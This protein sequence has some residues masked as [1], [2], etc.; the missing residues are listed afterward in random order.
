MSLPAESA[1]ATRSEPDQ[2]RPTRLGRADQP[3]GRNRH[4]E[5]A[6]V[7]EC[8]RTALRDSS[9]GRPGGGPHFP[10]GTLAMEP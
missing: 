4:L 8:N 7:R 1:I 6:S 2:A 10:P 3:A 9:S 5:Y